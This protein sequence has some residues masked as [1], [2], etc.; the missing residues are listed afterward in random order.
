MNLRSIMD[1]LYTSLSKLNSAAQNSLSLISKI[2][3]VEV[4]VFVLREE[5]LV[6]VVALNELLEIVLGNKLE[7]EDDDEEWGSTGTVNRVNWYVGTIDI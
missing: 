2:C 5:K 7:A 3:F 1:Q 6:I 4:V